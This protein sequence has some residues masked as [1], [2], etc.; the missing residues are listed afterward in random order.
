M[1]AGLSRLTVMRTA[2]L[3]VALKS[4]AG[5]TGGGTVRY[6]EWSDGRRKIDAD[7]S[8]VAGLKAEIVVK[9]AP[10][11]ALACL[12]G[13]VAGR[14]DTARGAPIPALRP[15]DLIEIRQNG[16]AILRGKFGPV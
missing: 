6:T 14:L 2:R 3:G 15:D 9:G 10:I 8:G 11:G 5:F 7:L 16:V 12:E 4:V 1:L 13:A